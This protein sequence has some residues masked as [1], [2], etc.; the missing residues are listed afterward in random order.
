MGGGTGEE[1]GSEEDRRERIF[2]VRFCLGAAAGIGELGCELSSS[3]FRIITLL[4]ALLLLFMKTLLMLGLPSLLAPGA[5][6]SASIS[7]VGELPSTLSEAVM[8]AIAP[9]S[10]LNSFSFSDSEYFAALA[11]ALDFASLSPLE[12]FELRMEEEEE[13]EEEEPLISPLETSRKHDTH[14][15][16]RPPPT[17]RSTEC[18]LQS[19]QKT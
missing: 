9:D 3:F 15:R 17:F 7:T 8:V 4:R 10:E 1:G 5:P 2:D 16:S 19:E 18:L 14:A 13:V 12:F 11:L 6:T